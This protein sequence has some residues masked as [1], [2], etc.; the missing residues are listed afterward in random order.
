MVRA[1]FKCDAV[2]PRSD[3]GTEVQVELSAVT[4]GSDENKSWSRYT[5]SGQLTMGITNPDA[6]AQ[7][8]VGKE[9]YLDFTPA[10]E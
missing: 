1:K 10:G 4:S 5:P 7:F 3:D 9:Y 8:E 6:V 2:K